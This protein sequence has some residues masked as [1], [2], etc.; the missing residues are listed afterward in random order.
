MSPYFN[1]YSP[2]WISKCSF[3]Q[4]SCGPRRY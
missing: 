2:K 4:L 1:I 3:F